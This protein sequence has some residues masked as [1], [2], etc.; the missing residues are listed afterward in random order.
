MKIRR[1]KKRAKANPLGIS[2]PEEITKLILSLMPPDNEGWLRQESRF[3]VDR[4]TE[5]RYGPLPANTYRILWHQT[6]V[7]KCYEL[8]VEP[9]S[10]VLHNYGVE[11]ELVTLASTDAEAIAAAKMIILMTKGVEAS[12]R[13][14]FRIMFGSA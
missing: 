14:Q 7:D 4:Y 2:S 5:V 13:A 3:N 9:Q 10:V 1:P 11:N 8:L 6:F 12:E